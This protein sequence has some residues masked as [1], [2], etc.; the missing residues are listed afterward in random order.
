MYTLSETLSERKNF[1]KSIIYERKQT[2]YLNSKKV[3]IISLLEPNRRESAIIS[4]I[5]SKF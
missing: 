5:E 2:S 3:A 4:H 1:L